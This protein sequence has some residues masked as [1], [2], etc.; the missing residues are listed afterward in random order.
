M[1]ID[2]ATAAPPDVYAALTGVVNPRP[3][4]WVLTRSPAGVLNLAPFSF[5]NAFG[6]NPPVVVF[7]PT[8]TRDGRKKDTLVNVDATGECV[9]HVATAELR[10]QVNLTSKELPPDESEVELAG[11]HTVPSVK[12]T[13]PRLAESPAALE[14]KVR[15]VVEVGDGP[16]AGRLVVCEVVML[17]VADAV[18]GGN[19]RPDPHKLR[20]VGRLGGDYW[21][22]TSDLF[23]LPRP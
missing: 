10:E 7:S 14:C 13:V 15:Q 23:K 12:V 8:L 2:P 17:H 20:T 9:V 11:L 21:C 16:I 19:G 6:S 5:F 22:H 18:L 4:A 3:I 1:T